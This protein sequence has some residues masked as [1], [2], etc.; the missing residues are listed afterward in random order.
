M[1]LYHV[2]RKDIYDDFIKKDG[3]KP[4]CIKESKMFPKCGEAI[5]F[6]EEIDD[7][8]DF[9]TQNFEPDNIKWVILEVDIHDV[10]NVC[11]YISRGYIL[12]S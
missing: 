11:K 6:S 3:L 10:L 12:S 5:F 9:A 8:V 7:V 4:I 2:T 1:K